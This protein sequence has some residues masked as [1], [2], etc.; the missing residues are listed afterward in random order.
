[1]TVWQA[2]LAGFVLFALAYASFVVALLALG[3]RTDA[4]A[5]AGF[6][7]DCAVLLNR[8]RADE[9]FGRRQRWLLGAAIAYIAMPI[10]LIPDVVPILGQLDD[11]LV[12]ALVLRSVA[13][14][15]G[16]EAIAAHWPGP[17]RSLAIVLRLAG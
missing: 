7:P 8:L 10:D 15:A 6:L 16:P 17:E 4:R 5:L 3:R 9:S 12:V 11:A 14:A 13:R 1:M 2:A